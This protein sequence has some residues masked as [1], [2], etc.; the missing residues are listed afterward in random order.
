M[1]LFQL[2]PRSVDPVLQTLNSVFFS[3]CALSQDMTFLESPGQKRLD[4]LRRYSVM[5]GTK[6]YG[7]TTYSASWMPKPLS[8]ILWLKNESKSMG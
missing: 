8:M 6:R 7:F 1:L 5:M 2:C 4:I 3:C